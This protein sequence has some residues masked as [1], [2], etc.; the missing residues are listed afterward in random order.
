MKPSYLLATLVALCAALPAAGADP[1][2]ATKAA[3]A[4]KPAAKVAEGA[5]PKPDAKGMVPL[6]LARGKAATASSAQGENVAAH[7][8]DGDLATRWCAGRRQGPQWLQVD[9]GKAEALTGCLIVWEKD[10]AAYSFKVEGSAD[11]KAWSLLADRTKAPAKKQIEEVKFDKAAGDKPARYVRLTVEGTSAGAWACAYEF[12]VFGNQTVLAS[13]QAASVKKAAGKTVKPGPGQAP[14]D[15]AKA[16]AASKPPP[17]Y[18]LTLFAG[19]PDVNYPTC[20]TV[21][22]NGQVFVG[23]DEQGSL[24]KDPGRGRVVKCIDTDGDGKADKFV[25]FAK[26]DHPRGLVYDAGKLYV[27]HPPFLSVYTDPGG[28]A[29]AG[30][31]EVLITGISTEEHVKARGADHTTNG[32]RMGIDGWIYIAMGDYGCKAVGKD[33]VPFQFH[34]GGILRVRPDGTGLEAYSRYTRNI[35]DVAIDPFMNVFTRDNTNDG[36][37]WNDRLAYDVPTGNYGYPSLFLHFPGEFIDCLNDYGGGSPCGSLF[38]DEPN[39]GELGHALLT[40]EWGRSAI[41]RHPLTPQGAGYKTPTPEEKVMDVPRATDIDV[42]A[43]GRFFITSWAN[44]GFAYSGPNVGYMLRLTPKA[45]A[46]DVPDFTKIT[47]DQLVELVG[48][49]SGVLRQAAQRELLKRGDSLQRPAVAAA[50]QK[51]AASDK[52]LAGR[53]AAIF[54]LKQWLGSGADAALT[55]LAKKDDLREFALRALADVKGATGVSAAPFVAA[56]K[57]PNPRCA[58]KPPGA[59]A[60]SVGRRTRPP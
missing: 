40:C 28:D 11:G 33:G 52:P 23:I 17:G 12:E 44:G 53:V 26:M 54:T 25:T 20:V 59:S 3:P 5:G 24:G 22:P 47:P 51:I 41:F 19:P 4:K 7:A 58:C 38:T 1:K 2:P 31:S 10:D 30:K 48:S 57:D 45:A 6:D 36:D 49:T 15:P 29:E 35:Y 8:T 43:R 16:L 42:D 32:I 39:A 46:A 9:L 56:L 13:A 37:K 55:E 34:G 21:T 18:D 27:L 50:L 60:G 14:F